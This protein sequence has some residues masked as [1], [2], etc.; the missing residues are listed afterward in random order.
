MHSSV[1]A[2]H[3]AM[4]AQPKGREGKGLTRTFRPVWFTMGASVSW[5]RFGEMR[6]MESIRA[7]TSWPKCRDSVTFSGCAL[8]GQ[9]A[10]VP[11]NLDGEWLERGRKVCGSGGRVTRLFLS[12]T[13]AQVV[14]MIQACR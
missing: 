8:A 14:S 6:G 13:A 9:G 7:F 1:L 11:D 2:W 12:V 10:V 4:Q 5:R 3:T